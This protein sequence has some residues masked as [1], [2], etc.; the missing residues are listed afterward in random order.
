MLAWGGGPDWSTMWGY[1]YN[2]ASIMYA[3]VQITGIPDGWSGPSIQCVGDIYGGYDTY[4]PN[5]MTYIGP[6]TGVDY[7]MGFQPT[8]SSGALGWRGSCPLEQLPYQVLGFTRDSTMIDRNNYG[9][10]YLQYTASEATHSGPG[11]YS[12]LD[13]SIDWLYNTSQSAPIE[14]SA[15]Y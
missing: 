2:F 9:K 7:A 1:S 4:M 8:V 5:V 12:R 13:Y 6:Y 10:W 14:W 15:F 3:N 11:S